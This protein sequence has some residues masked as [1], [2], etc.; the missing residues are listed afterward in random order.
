MGLAIVRELMTAMGGS[1]SAER[2]ASGGTT[3]VLRFPLRL[4]SS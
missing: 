2:A 3:I 1:A 4:S